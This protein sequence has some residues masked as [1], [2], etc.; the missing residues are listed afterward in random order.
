M[1]PNGTDE[2]KEFKVN[3]R[4][5]KRWMILAL[6]VPALAACQQQAAEAPAAEA[7]ASAASVPD[8][9][10]GIS[11]SGGQ[12]VLPVVKGRP[13]AVYFA[14]TNGSDAAVTLAA[15]TVEG[16]AKAEMHETKGGAM[17]DMP[18]MKH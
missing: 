12:L 7:S 1:A 4:F 9:K 10:P 14:V 3:C 18:G 6:S 15:V 2:T 5:S 11:A 13:G 16:G 17:A 8:A